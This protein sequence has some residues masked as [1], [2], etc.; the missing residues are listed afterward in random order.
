MQIIRRP[1]TTRG[2]CIVQS[3][4]PFHIVQVSPEFAS[5]FGYD[6]HELH[7]RSMKLLQGPKCRSVRFEDMIK[8]LKSGKNQESELDVDKKDGSHIRTSIRVSMLE[9][10]GVSVGV[11]PAVISIPAT[12]TICFL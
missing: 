3:Y 4:K 12:I 8:A 10:G 7:G 11:S 6:V 5:Y 2:F 1:Q 9:E